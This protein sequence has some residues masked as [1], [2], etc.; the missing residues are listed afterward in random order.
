[1]MAGL[2][3]V[4]ESAGY[5]SS[6][7]APPL[8]DH[9][10]VAAAAE[11]GQLADIV[12]GDFNCTPNSPLYREL[13]DAFGPSAQDL[14]GNTPFVTIDG[15]SGEGGRRETLDHVFVRRASPFQSVQPSP[16]VAFSAARRQERLS[17][18]F[19]IEAVTFNNPGVL[20]LMPEFETQPTGD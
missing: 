18:H 3:L 4:I 12:A 19:G 6:R 14:S 1:V 13:S 7:P 2:V 11:D 5:A 17:D 10:L 15:L 9:P 20:N 16:H 8:L